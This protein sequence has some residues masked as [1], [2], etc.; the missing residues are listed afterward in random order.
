M[1]HKR[2]PQPQRPLPMQLPAPRRPRPQRT[3][4][5]RRPAQPKPRPRA[6]RVRP[7]RS[8]PRRKKPVGCSAVRSIGANMPRKWGGG[9]YNKP[10]AGAERKNV[11][12]RGYLITDASPLGHAG[13]GPFWIEKDG[14]VITR[15][16]KSI[17]SAKRT[18]EN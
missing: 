8:K 11:A 10:L 9:Y 2:S 5:T 14:Y 13:E 12:H 6:R 4:S 16:E 7:K 18:I 3:R 17:E 1:P 15:S